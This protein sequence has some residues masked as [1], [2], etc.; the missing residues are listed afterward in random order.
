MESA[1]LCAAMG[2]G[3]ALLIALKAYAAIMGEDK[4]IRHHM[5]RMEVLR[6]A[7]DRRAAAQ[8]QSPTE[9]PK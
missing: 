9:P 5:R 7:D 2:G 8:Q 3:V 6:K 4:Q 1:L